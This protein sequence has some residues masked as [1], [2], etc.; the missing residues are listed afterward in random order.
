M[1]DLKCSQPDP[2]Q[3]QLQSVG[4]DPTTGDYTGQYKVPAAVSGSNRRL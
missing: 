4:R 2:S 1:G 3:C